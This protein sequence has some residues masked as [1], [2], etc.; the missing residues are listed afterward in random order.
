MLLD[1]YRRAQDGFDAVLAQVPEGAWD[2]QSECAAWSVRDVV[3]HVVWGQEFIL[4]WGT[5]RL[6]TSTDGAP[7]S[8]H[9][10]PVAGPDPLTRWR[11]ARAAAEQVLTPAGLRQTYETRG[12]GTIPLSTFIEAVT[13]DFLAH[14]WDIGHACGLDVRTSPDLLPGSWEWARANIVHRS[15]TGIGPELTPPDGSDEQTRWLAFLGRKAW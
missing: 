15:P 5:G 13:T 10:G 1:S 8:A 6:F 3:G 4:H 14:T 12:F 9:P 11:A 2:K 7:G